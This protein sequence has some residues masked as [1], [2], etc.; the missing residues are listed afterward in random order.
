MKVNITSRDSSNLDLI[1][2]IKMQEAHI[3]RKSKEEKR[4]FPDEKKT[5]IK[6]TQD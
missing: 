3:L 2:A 1:R 6:G 4:P 5:K